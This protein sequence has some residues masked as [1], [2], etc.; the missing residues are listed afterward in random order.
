MRKVLF[1]ILIFTANIVVHSQT[2]PLPPPPI[3]A[4]WNPSILNVNDTAADFT[5]QM[6]NG[7]TITLSDLRGQVVLL[8]F[9]AISCSP[10]IRKLRAFP[11]LIE[12]FKNSPFVLLPIL[13]DNMDATKELMARL[14]ED[15]VDFNI[16]IAGRQI[17]RLYGRGGFPM[18]FLIDKEGIIRYVSIGYSEE[19]GMDELA[20]KIQKLLDEQEP[21][22]EKI[23]DSTVEYGNESEVESRFKNNGAII[24]VFAFLL[25]FV[26]GMV[27]RKMRKK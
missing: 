24:A 3:P 1:L 10:C 11:S 22:Q 25:V 23:E 21:L 12:P 16:G 2:A 4:D 6:I 20:T 14:K 27:L 19:E 9:G 26:V 18:A 5:V 15:G 8:S 13:M 17:Y 7:E